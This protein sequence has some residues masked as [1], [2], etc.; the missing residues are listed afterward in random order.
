MK[1][2]LLAPAGSYAKLLTAFHFGADAAYVG[3]K[4]FSLRAFADNFSSEELKNAV[5]F[6]HRNGKKLYVTA[7]VFARNAD[8]QAMEEYFQFLSRSGVDA[9]IL[10]DPGVV[11]AAKK[12]APELSVHLSTQANTTNKYAVKFWTEQ[13]VSRVIL[14]RELPVKD[15]AEIH[16]FVPETELEAF[17]HGAMCISYSGR[18]L[19]SDYLDGRSSN[20]GACVQSCR[21]NY[22]VRAL[23]ATNGKSEWLPIEEDGRGAYIFNSKDLNMIRRLQELETAGVSSFKI[24]GRMKSGYYL[25]TVINAYRRAMD[26]AELSLAETE[27]CNVAHREYT[28][29][30]AFGEN[31]STVNYNDSQSKGEYVYIADVLGYAEGWL[32]AEM[33]NRF[34]KG[35]VL[36]ILSP[37][38]NFGK[39]FVVADMVDSNGTEVEDAKLVQEKYKLRCPYPVKQGDYLRRKTQK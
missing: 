16:D 30:Y 23:N 39:T 2:E 15:I 36:E 28:E 9:A 10:S 12:A 32:E 17:V 5:A 26:G 25:A 20:K 31:S 13:G 1:A 7:N 14:A 3:G 11:Y 8:L 21:W 37:D 35:D 27:L 6:A 29:A 4:N 38:G 34:K 33:R 24:E 18:C 22:E 19:L